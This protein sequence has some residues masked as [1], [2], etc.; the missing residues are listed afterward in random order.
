VYG[1][2]IESGVDLGPFFDEVHFANMRKT[3]GGVRGDGKI[4][5]PEGWR[6]PDHARVF[7][8]VYGVELHEVEHAA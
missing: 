6:P 3:N 4:L 7:R 8:E 2:A 5:K 1:A